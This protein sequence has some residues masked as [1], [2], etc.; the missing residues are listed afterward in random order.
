MTEATPENQPLNREV[1]LRFPDGSLHA[2]G[3]ETGGFF[4]GNNKASGP[5]SYLTRKGDY[6]API[7]EPPLVEIE[8]AARKGI[9]PDTGRITQPAWLSVLKKRQSSF[10]LV[11][12]ALCNCFCNPRFTMTR[13]QWIWVRRT[14]SLPPYHPTTLLPFCPS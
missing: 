7:P 14:S 9:D 3:D 11:R 1:S 10:F 8:E 2:G 13:A 12:W 6:E 5:V 4:D